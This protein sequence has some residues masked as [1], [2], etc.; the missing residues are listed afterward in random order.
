MANQSDKSE[1]NSLDDQIDIADWEL[2]SALNNMEINEA[3]NA[4]GRKDKLV[5]KRDRIARR[6]AKRTQ[7]GA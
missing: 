1:D 6:D 2:K 5:A 4:L 3:R 7:G